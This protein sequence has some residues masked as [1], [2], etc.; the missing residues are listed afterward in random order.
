MKYPD[1]TPHSVVITHSGLFTIAGSEMVT[2]D[3]AENFSRSGAHVVVFAYGIN[4]LWRDKF[5]AIGVEVIAATDDDADSQ[6]A[7][8]D[9]DLVWVHHSVLPVSLLEPQTSNRR[10]VFS[11]LSHFVPLELPFSFEIESHL[12]SAIVFV[13]QEAQNAILATGLLD[14]VDESRFIV[15][16]NPAPDAFFREPSPVKP[17]RLRRLLI[18]SNHLPP[19]VIEAVAL[20]DRNV[21]VQIVGRQSEVGASPK[22]IEPADLHDVD[23]VLTIGKTVQFAF[24]AG[25]PVYCY[26]HF[27]GPGWLAESNFNQ[28]RYYNFSGRGFDRKSAQQIAQEVVDRFDDASATARNLH[29]RY[30]NDFVISHALTNVLEHIEAPPDRYEFDPRV[31]Q[32]QSIHNELLSGLT[33]AVAARDA[34]IQHL[35]TGLALSE[36]AR[37]EAQ[38]QRDEAQRVR[39]EAQ[40]ARDEAQSREAELSSRKSIRIANWLSKFRPRYH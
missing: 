18:V 30:A 20:L 5:A 40:R 31:V 24:V 34:T 8:I 19:E 39:D 4:Q 32:F 37:D 1:F 27:G 9:P 15:L 12:A 26:D 28:A 14:S 2:L 7:H 16:P 38:H 17:D 6:L 22:I 36:S 3:L 21:E 13:S 23:A 25:V 29:H 35:S 11:H 10:F 33:N